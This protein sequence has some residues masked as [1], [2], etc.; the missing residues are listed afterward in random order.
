LSLILQKKSP[1]TR[2]E[3][4]G[5]GFIP[6][7]PP[8]RRPPFPPN[9][10]HWGENIPPP[11][12]HRTQWKQKAFPESRSCEQGLRAPA[13]LK[14]W[15]S[16][17]KGQRIQKSYRFSPGMAPGRPQIIVTGGGGRLSRSQT[18]N[19]PPPIYVRLFFFSGGPTLQYRGLSIVEPPVLILGTRSKNKAESGMNREASSLC[20][21]P[22]LNPESEAL[23][24]LECLLGAAAPHP[25]FFGRTESQTVCLLP[26]SH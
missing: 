4:R 26:D 18:A 19:T 24:E 17:S 1:G 22:C 21:P 9:V 25:G 16:T 14:S 10:L 11:R 20:G 15:K 7:C 3:A 8:T 2:S 23:S 13:W 6:W 12:T 5:G